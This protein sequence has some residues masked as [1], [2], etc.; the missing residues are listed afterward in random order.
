LGQTTQQL[1]HSAAPDSRR[2]EV[3]Y[4]SFETLERAASQLKPDELPSLRRW[5]PHDD[6]AGKWAATPSDERLAVCELDEPTRAVL[7]QIEALLGQPLVTLDDT[8]RLEGADLAAAIRARLE[9]LL[10]TARQT[11]KPL[12]VSEFEAL[13][14]LPSD[15]FDTFE[16][17]FSLDSAALRQLD[18]EGSSLVAFGYESMTARYE[19]HL[20]LRVAEAFVTQATLDMLRGRGGLGRE[21]GVYYGR[22]I[23]DEEADDYPIAKVLRELGADIAAVCPERLTDK[24]EFVRSRQHDRSWRGWDDEDNLLDNDDFDEASAW[25]DEAQLGRSLHPH[26]RH[27]KADR[28]VCPRCKIPVEQ[29]G[30]ARLEHWQQTHPMGPDL[31]AVEVAWVLYGAS[32]DSKQLEVVIPVD[33]RSEDGTRYWTLDTLADHLGKKA[34]G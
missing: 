34:R 29:V 25:P 13:H 16:D 19:F 5:G 8:Q 28:P 23:S 12:E 18:P 24:A 27:S 21:S 31:T 2:H 32:R 30:G 1:R 33:Y 20:P 3:D 4:W 11:R 9:G 26:G 6:C 15:L 17:W 14:L 10:A 7:G 22:S